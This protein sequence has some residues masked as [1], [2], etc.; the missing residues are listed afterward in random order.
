MP[1]EET[2][3]LLFLLTVRNYGSLLINMDKDKTFVSQVHLPNDV[4][5]LQ[6][7]ESY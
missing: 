4:T 1:K 7:C 2:E 5:G 6:K 3:K